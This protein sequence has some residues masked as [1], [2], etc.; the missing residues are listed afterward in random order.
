MSEINSPGAGT[1]GAGHEGLENAGYD[2]ELQRALKFR[3]L[4]VYGMVFMVPIAPMGIYGFVSKEGSGM[5]P[6]V[7][8]VGIVAM[9]FTA[10]SYR[11]M[12][13][14]FPFAG[15][16]YSYVQRGFNPHV[17]FI[18][19]WMIL[20]DYLLVPALLYAFS[21]TWLHA[22]APGIP[23]FVWV[24][25]FISIITVVNV[26]GITVAA[27]A[28]F[29]LLAIE[30]VALVL[31][32]FFAV[33]FVFVDGG[34]AG[35]FSL[36]P[37]YQPQHMGLGFIATA[38]S[39]AVLSFLGFDAISTLSE[40]AERPERTVGNATVA[41]L[42]LL[43]VIFMIETYAAA[44]VHPNYANLDP[45]LGF[46]DLAREAGGPFLYYTL[47]IINVIASG[48][49]DALVAQLAVSRI[50]YSIS[51]DRLLPFSGFLS[52][53]HPT[54]RTP[55]NATLLVAVL[56]IVI[57][58]GLSLETIAKFVNFGA[59]TSF[60]LLNLTVV[61]YFFVKQGRRGFKGYFTYL[62]LPLLGLAVIAYVWSGF[63]RLTFIFGFAWMAV[64]IALG[65]VKSRGYKE[66][67][68]ALQEM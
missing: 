10:L 60:M 49:A 68:T 9:T 51:R 3:D 56:S 58:L 36:A 24:L 2:Q 11:Q 31:F 57:A 34:G 48:I 65:A 52:R 63:D 61:I 18:A 6:L 27:K 43:G 42:V 8:L 26:R 50:L 12:S 41:A 22:L 53:I 39:I 64:G 4:L 37:L 28:N 19:G 45:A 32:L 1:D 13:R 17:G 5:V 67:P 59:L 33:K 25:L 14:R 38:T 47:I 54:Y 44:L 55:V 46:F 21:A 40:E 20:I 15:S 62:I 30:L 16:V 7:Y 35:G 29:T 23:L 66:V